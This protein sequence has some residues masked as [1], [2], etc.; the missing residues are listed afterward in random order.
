MVMELDP[1]RLVEVKIGEVLRPRVDGEV[2]WQCFSS[3][4][5]CHTD[6]SYNNLLASLI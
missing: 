1:N 5:R 2:V 6:C 3:K 4:S